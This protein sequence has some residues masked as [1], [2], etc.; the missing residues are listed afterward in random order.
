MRR[1]LCS[2]VTKRIA[3][4]GQAR[5]GGLLRGQWLGDHGR[6]AEEDA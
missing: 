4:I 3:A 5:I 6:I 1:D 2:G